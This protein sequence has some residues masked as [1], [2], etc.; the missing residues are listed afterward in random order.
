MYLTLWIIYCDLIL[1]VYF[2]AIISHHNFM[3]S[4]LFTIYLIIHLFIY[5]LILAGMPNLRHLD[6]KKIADEEKSAA[7]EACMGISPFDP[8]EVGAL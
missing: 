2:T 3:F 6:L 4:P 7:N 8:V 1:L 5:F